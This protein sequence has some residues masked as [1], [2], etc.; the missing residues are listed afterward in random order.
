MGKEKAINIP[1]KQHPGT[2]KRPPLDE[3]A[4]LYA[5]HTAKEIGTMYGVSESTVRSWVARAR[6]RAAKT[7]EE[8]PCPVRAG[9]HTQD[10]ARLEDALDEIAGVTS[11]MD[12]SVFME[13]FRQAC[14]GVEGNDPWRIIGTLSRSYA[15]ALNIGNT[16]YAGFLKQAV[17]ILKEHRDKEETQ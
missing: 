13:G 5:E 7:A 8:S 9:R 12:S 14:M 17:R 1:L 6:K 4:K 3:L 2:S 10:Y 11:G 16:A 15:Q